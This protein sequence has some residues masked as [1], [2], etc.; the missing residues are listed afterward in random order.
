GAADRGVLRRGTACAAADRHLV[1]AEAFELLQTGDAPIGR[2][3]DRESVDEIVAQRAGLPRIGP[4]VLLHVV[5]ADQRLEVRAGLGRDRAVG[6][7]V[8]HREAREGGKAAAHQAT[9]FLDLWVAAQVDIGAEGDGARI[10]PGIA[11]RLLRKIY[12]PLQ[13]L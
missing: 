4:R 2:P 7:A 5:V 9:R 11:A 8:H 1:Q 10:E 3:D 12:A 13:A 6:L